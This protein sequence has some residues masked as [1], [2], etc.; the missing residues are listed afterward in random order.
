MVLNVAVTLLV[1][2]IDTTQVPVPEQP[3]PDQPA[4]VEPPEAEA[5][6]VTEV[7]EV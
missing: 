2:L 7:P 4:K 6:K 5:D 3:S 1:A